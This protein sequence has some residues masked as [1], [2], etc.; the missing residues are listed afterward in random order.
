MRPFSY[1]N[2]IGYVHITSWCDLIWS[3]LILFRAVRSETC[4]YVVLDWTHTTV[5]FAFVSYPEF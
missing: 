4:L 1:I 3:D 5:G 2:I